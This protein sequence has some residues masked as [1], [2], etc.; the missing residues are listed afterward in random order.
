MI[1]LAAAAAAPFD[2]I[3]AWHRPRHIPNLVVSKSA[4]GE[5]SVKAAASIQG[6]SDVATVSFQDTIN[7]DG[8]SH[9]YLS[10]NSSF[11]DEQQA[12]AAGYLE[13]QMTYQKIYQGVV[14]SGANFTYDT[15][16]AAFLAAN[17]EFMKQNFALH[18]DDPYWHQLW[19]LYLQL[20]G[21]IYG[22]ADAT[23]N[24]AYV[25][26]ATAIFNIQLSGD[27]EDLAAAVGI[28]AGATTL[29]NPRA[30]YRA[31][32][33]AQALGNAWEQLPS[34]E[35]GERQLGSLGI[36]D[37]TTLPGQDGSG[38]CSALVRLLPDGS[39][40]YFSQVT[41]SGFEDMT[42]T[43]KLYSLPYTLAG[44]KPGQRSATTRSSIPAL[45]GLQS[46]ST[47][48]AVRMGFSSEPGSLFSGDD[49]YTMS[50][51]LAMLETTIGNS[52]ATLYQLYVKP[53]TVLEWARNVVANR[54]AVDGASWAQIYSAFNSG[55][56]NNENIIIDYN[57]FTPGSPP[58]PGLLTALDQI[59]GF[60]EWHDITGELVANGYVAS[61][62]VA[63]FP[64]IYNM[65]G[66]FPLYE[67]YGPWFSFNDTARANIFR[68]DAVKITTPQAMEAMMRYN[69]FKQDPLSTQG[70]GSNPPYSA[71]NAI[72]AR[73]D[74]NSAAGV[75]PISALGHRDHAGI[76]AKYTSLGMMKG[77]AGSAP[78]GWAANARGISGP[79]YDTQ[80]V[81]V[82]STSDYASLPHVGQP[83]A[84]QFP[85]TDML[86][87]EEEE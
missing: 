40:V 47:V 55:T 2:D 44:V 52:N 75:Y 36:P 70:C 45:H 69:N 68:R 79:S 81:F 66:M 9:L 62:N 80:P 16:L 20:D 12:Y 67:Q 74:L 65:S 61:Y 3:W 85:W 48:P 11:D 18:A 60:I 71:E 84:W 19:L 73:D 1:S 56:Y 10:T 82:W 83:D 14:N 32:V 38:H 34:E 6:L 86:W 22:Y 5:S 39:D 4:T 29:R 42:R 13:A 58:A 21:M 64:A 46:S 51:G 57:K 7:T 53:T 77:S 23:A 24:S 50:S 26:P 63:R 25:L 31:K 8:W 30:A 87:P 76:D 35:R 41:W 17:E 33:R 43:Y 59:P 72:A 15:K 78:Y 37:L 27:M 49:F 54:L 28:Q